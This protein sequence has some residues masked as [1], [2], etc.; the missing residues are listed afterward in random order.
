[1]FVRA[2]FWVALTLCLASPAMAQ[3]PVVLPPVD[4]PV[5]NLP[6]LDLGG[7]RP[8]VPPRQLPPLPLDGCD[9][10]PEGWSIFGPGSAPV[11]WL[12]NLDLA[13]LKPHVKNQIQLNEGMP[14]MYTYTGLVSTPLDWTVAPRFDLGWR[15]AQG[16][17][18]LLV[19]YQFLTTA[20]TGG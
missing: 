18:E 13:I 16:A 12:V 19:S 20:G 3:P 15:F 14:S 9:P 11:A 8:P 1:M 10:G 5:Q 17:G 6:P 7:G 2:C 4:G